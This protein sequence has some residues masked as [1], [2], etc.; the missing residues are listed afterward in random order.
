MAYATVDQ[1]AAVM[2]L[3]VTV[4]NQEFLQQCLDAAAQEIDHYCGRFAE[5]PLPVDDALAGLVNVVRGVEWYKAND[6]V[7][8]GVGFADVG[9]LTVPKDSFGRYAQALTPHLQTFGVS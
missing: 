4:K 8:G 1:L 9:I 7:F 5:S 3:T 6:A 2:R